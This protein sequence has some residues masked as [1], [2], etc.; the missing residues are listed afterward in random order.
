M[1]KKAMRVDFF[2][3]YFS[4]RGWI[5]ERPICTFDRCTPELLW[6]QTYLI[7]DKAVL[8][9]R[10]FWTA[11]D[12]LLQLIAASNAALWQS[13]FCRSGAERSRHGP[14]GSLGT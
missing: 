7:A 10:R 1:M 13:E 9:L 6:S 2:M 5:S 3:R 11:E 4:K 12:A 8:I 14:A